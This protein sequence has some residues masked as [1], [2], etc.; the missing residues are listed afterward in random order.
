M[1]EHGSAR[2]PLADASVLVTGAAGFIGSHVCEALCRVGARVVAAG[3]ISEEKRGNLAALQDR[4]D[5]V[6]ARLTAHLMQSLLEQETFDYVFHFAGSPDP[7]ASTR[8]PVKDFRLNSALTLSLLEACRKAS[9]IPAVVLASSAAVYGSTPTLPIG[10]T[11][12]T[13]PI[14]PY[15]ASKLAAE[16]YARVYSRRFEVPTAVMRIFSAYGPRL[17]RQV[18]HDFLARLHENPSSLKVRTTGVETRD[19]IFIDDIVSAALT[20]A[21]I[22]PLAG[23]PYNVGTGTETSIRMLAKLIVD[24]L[25]PDC[26]V[27]FED[28]T[29]TVGASRWCAD[30]R[31]LRGLGWT[32]TVGIEEG[33]A[34]TAAWLSESRVA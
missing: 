13:D 22:A 29:D 30:V 6:P 26:R 8:A 32:P 19:F 28:R 34:R 33:V 16:I 10:E 12:P 7:R 14:S 15:G 23:E 24:R 3:P 1:T 2:V 27:E 4:I 31:K 5:V 20:I 25:G 21:S 9:R 18:V 11:A 17:R